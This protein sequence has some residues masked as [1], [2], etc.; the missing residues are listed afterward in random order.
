ME[1]HINAS[2]LLEQIEKQSIAIYG[3]GHIAKKFLKAIELYQCKKNILCF[4]VSSLEQSE[5]EIGGIPVRSLDWLAEHKDIL[6]CI[7][8][9]ESLRRDIVSAIQNIGV[10]HHV[11]IYPCLY[12]LLLGLPVR[13][14]I[15]VDL[16][17]IVR[18]CE[19][20]YRL[21][22]R[23]AAIEQYFGR[24]QIGFD[25]YRRAQALHSSPETAKERLSAFCR[26]IAEWEKNGY[27]EQ[28]RIAINTSYEI[29]DG[30]HRVALAKYYSQKQIV[31][32]I[33]EKRIDVTELH[34]ENAMLTDKVLFMEG[35]SD[36]EM[37]YLDEIN[38]MIKCGSIR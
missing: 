31:C 25:M 29:I 14:N 5:K 17:D 33:Y 16:D 20:D 30:N 11:W 2:N 27:K 22:I 24:N 6:V 13:T 21:A 9:H 35:F 36:K 10:F 3:A 1:D 32:D 4:V 26:L 12:E 34:G 8:V 15:K 37:E 23:Y 28:S 19:G 18:T 38:R 7:A